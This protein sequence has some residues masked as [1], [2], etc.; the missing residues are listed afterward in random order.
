[1]FLDVTVLDKS[2]KPVTQGLTKDDFLLTD[3]AAPQ[4]IFSFEPPETHKISAANLDDAPDGKAP[5]TIFVLDRLNSTSEEFVDLRAELMK[6]FEAQPAQ[7]A[8]PGE[9]MVIGNRSLELVQGYTRSRED[10]LTAVASVESELPI[11]LVPSYTSDRIQR[12]FDA[13][14]QIA[15]QNAGISGRK[16]LVWVGRGSP[17]ASTIRF[18]SATQSRFD[19]YIRDTTNLLV[20]ARLSLFVIYPRVKSYGETVA[21]S[22]LDANLTLGRSGSFGGDMNFGV[23]VNE[24]G[25]HLFYNNNDVGKEIDQ[26]ERFGSN[27]YTLTYQP[28]EVDKD[29]K[30]RKITVTVKDPSLRVVTKGG[31]FA[32]SEQEAAHPQQK[33]MIDLAESLQ[34]TIPFRGLDAQVTKLVKHEDAGTVEVTLQVRTRDLHWLP[35]EDGKQRTELT[36][37]NAAL[38][39]RRAILA[40]KVAQVSLTVAPQNI[41]KLQE[42]ITHFTVTVRVPRR[43]ERLRFVVEAGEGGRMGS[44]EVDRA[45]LD[46]A[47]DTP[48]AGPQ[49]LPARTA[50]KSGSGGR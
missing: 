19:D 15:L 26:S 34:S 50:V 7:L 12:S 5:L 33:R 18:S 31:Y 6:Y 11:K 44:V 25:G 13:L 16:L 49:L 24:T 46:K 39:G 17:E 29:G 3:G 40:S 9:L 20:K 30:F 21:V 37:A 23:L 48:T 27:Y 2:G 28:T 14:Q 4:R 43:T 32:E 36:L 42:A 38:S 1:V 41:P 8:A 45:S 35:A 22:E 10:L 47:P